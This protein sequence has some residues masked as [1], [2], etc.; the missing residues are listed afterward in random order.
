MERV[1]PT[2]I[3]QHRRE[4]E[5][6][7]KRDRRPVLHIE[8]PRPEKP[9]GRDQPTTPSDSHGSGIIDFRL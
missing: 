9:W 1:H 6:Q 7:Q 4:R 2:I 3:E 5:R 8:G